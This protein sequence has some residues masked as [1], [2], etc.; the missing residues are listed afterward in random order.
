MQLRLLV[1]GFL[2]GIY[3]PVTVIALRNVSFR[4]LLRYSFSL[5]IVPAFVF[6]LIETL[7]IVHP[8]QPLG[9][10]STSQVS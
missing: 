7:M 3:L 6:L 10:R 9:G 5:T 2:L 1:V 8:L 4:P